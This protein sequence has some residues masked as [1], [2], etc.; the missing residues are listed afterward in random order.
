MRFIKRSHYI[1]HPL[2]ILRII[3]LFCKPDKLLLFSRRFLHCFFCCI[4]SLFRI[5]FLYYRIIRRSLLTLSTSD[6]HSCRQSQYY[7]TDNLLHIYTSNSS[8]ETLRPVRADS[9][10]AKTAF[11]AS[12][13]SSPEISGGTSFSRQDTQQSIN[14][15]LLC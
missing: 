1:L 14:P 8:T 15:E 6:H 11:I 9:K 7:K 12:N 2:C 4:S 10:A 3:H 5:S 13:A